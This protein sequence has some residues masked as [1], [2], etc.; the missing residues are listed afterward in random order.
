M[1]KAW[2]TAS[3]E[4]QYDYYIWLNDDTFTYPEMISTLLSASQKKKI[5]LLLSDQLQML[6]ILS[7]LMEDD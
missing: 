1:Y 4:R 6:N 3:S 2:E 5:K 7:L